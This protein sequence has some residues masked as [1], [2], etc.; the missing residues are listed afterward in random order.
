[1]VNKGYEVYLVMVMDFN[2]GNNESTNLPIVREFP[3]MF[4]EELLGFPL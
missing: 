1:M 2:G 3:D 4:P